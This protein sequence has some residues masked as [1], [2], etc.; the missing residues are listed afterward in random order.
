MERITAIILVA[1]GFVIGFVV[2]TQTERLVNERTYTFQIDGKS[3]ELTK[4]AIT[5]LRN[6]QLL[7][8]DEEEYQ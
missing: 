6:K 7:I 1:I 2:G 4:S 3:V 8:S 5:E